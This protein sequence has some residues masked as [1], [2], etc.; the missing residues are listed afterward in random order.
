MKHLISQLTKSFE[1][2]KR[3]RVNTHDEFLVYIFQTY[4]GRMNVCRS[5]KLK[6]K[7]IKERDSILQYVV[8]NKTE[9]LKHI[10]R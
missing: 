8:K 3:G 6:N 5:E 10:N 1:P 2:S 4:A 7:Y 9:V